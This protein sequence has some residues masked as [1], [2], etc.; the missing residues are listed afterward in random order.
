MLGVGVCWRG[1]GGDLGE[2]GFGG[3]GELRVSRG[4]RQGSEVIFDTSPTDQM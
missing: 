3:G 2:G 1:L 4:L